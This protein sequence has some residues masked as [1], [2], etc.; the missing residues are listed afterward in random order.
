MKA[1]D[2]DTKVV[3]ISGGTG[4]FV[5]L[6]GLKNYFRH[7]TALVSMADDGGSTGQLRDELGALPPGDVRQCLVALSC[8]PK[9]RDLFAYRFE[10][11]NLKGHSFGNLFLAALEKV[12]G[13]F[14]KGVELAGSILRTS[15]R[16]EPI[17]LD[18]VRLFVDDGETVTAHERDLEGKIFANK[19]PK[20]WLEPKPAANPAA[21]DAIRQA[22]LVVVAPGS[23][24]T[25][26]GAAL[27]V[28]GITQALKNSK[29]GKV[30]VCNLVNKPGQTDGFTVVDYVNELERL[31]DEQ[32]ID[33]V[34]YNTRQPSGQMLKR[35]AADGELPVELGDE[36]SL[37]KMHFKVVGADLLAREAWSDD[38]RSDQIDRTLIRHDSNRLAKQLA[39]LG[40]TR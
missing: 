10:E 25:S 6:S 28:P 39:E 30:Y 3:V 38:S 5:V 29:A 35:Y 2:S 21:L 20:V 8:S 23:L 36:E 13:D 32:F 12:T 11:G 1:I 16:V 15:G 22:D 4:G 34:V 27:T 19:R 40:R 24:Y 14:S 7:I 33:T 26:L 9:L 18:Q 37:E 17:T 31:A